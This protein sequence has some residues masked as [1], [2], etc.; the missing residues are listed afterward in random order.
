MA[1]E[2]SIHF[3]GVRGS[4]PVPG[5][6]TVRYGGNTS[7][8]EVRC[9]DRRI[10][11]D[12]GTGLYA[13]GQ[14]ETLEEADIL[15]SHTHIDHIQGFP[16][17]APLHRVSSV[18]R[19][20]AGH[21]LPERS[22]Q[23]VM[24]MMMRPPLFPMLVSDLKAA[25]AFIDF[26][27][28]EQLE[29]KHFTRDGIVIKTLALNHPDGATGYRLEYQGKSVC[30]ITDI[31]HPSDE[32][33]HQLVQFIR[34]CDVFIYDSTYTDETYENYAGWGHSTWQEGVRL[35]E[36][37][38]VGRYVMF[39]HDPEATDAELDQRDVALQKLRAGSVIAREGLV[40]T[41]K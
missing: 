35:A 36:K 32:L 9:G 27:A 41:L 14:V 23:E 34:G 10:I 33:D 8:V 22:I 1:K 26:H 30:Y 16:F 19:V 28:G 40:I 21:L 25:I 39:H 17:F 6:E 11:F 31:E 20:W 13:L 5:T 12:A 29:A 38:N 3:W 15:L 18:V 7:C 37:A 2:F 4:V 24:G